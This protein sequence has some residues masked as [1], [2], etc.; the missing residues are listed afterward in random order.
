MNVSLRQL[1]VFLAVA[2]LGSFSRAADAVGLT[3]SAVS[4]NIADLEARAGPASARPH[5]A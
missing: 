2:R 5:H 3:Q 1:R 4:R